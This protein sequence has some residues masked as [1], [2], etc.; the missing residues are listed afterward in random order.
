MTEE[1]LAAL[2]SNC[3][4]VSFTMLFIFFNLMGLENVF[5]SSIFLG[6]AKGTEL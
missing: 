5:N 2:F 6:C 3:G 1:G 4:Q